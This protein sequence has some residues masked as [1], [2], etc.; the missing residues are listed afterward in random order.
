MTENPMTDYE[1]ANAIKVG[2]W[3]QSKGYSPAQH[4]GEALTSLRIEDH[5]GILAG[6]PEPPKTRF[7]GLIKTQKRRDFLGVV[8]FKGS[9]DGPHCADENH[10]IFEFY[11]RKNKDCVEKLA[12]EMFEEFKVKISIILVREEPKIEYLLGD[13][14]W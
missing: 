7:F 1:E 12:K 3:L 8:C 9:V 10:W 6:N 11:G 5:V 14:D 2:K 13:Y 4:Y